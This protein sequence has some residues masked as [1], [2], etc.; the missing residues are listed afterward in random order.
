MSQAGFFSLDDGVPNANIVND[1]IDSQF[2]DKPATNRYPHSMA[3][4]II[5]SR[6]RMARILNSMD[7]LSE[8]MDSLDA[9]VTTVTVSDPVPIPTSIRSLLKLV[10]DNAK[11]DQRESYQL[12]TLADETNPIRYLPVT[13]TTHGHVM[14]IESPNRLSPTDGYIYRLDIYPEPV[15]LPHARDCMHWD[16]LTGLVVASEA[17]QHMGQVDPM[18]MNGY[19]VWTSCLSDAASETMVSNLTTHTSRYSPHRSVLD[20]VVHAPWNMYARLTAVQFDTNMSLMANAY[21]SLRFH[22]VDGAIGNRFSLMA[23]D[24]L[25]YGCSRFGNVYYDVSLHDFIV[26]LHRR[27]A[28]FTD[29]FVPLH[30]H[31]LMS[32]IG[33]RRA[34]GGGNAS[35]LDTPEGV[36][37]FRF[38]PRI[39]CH[40]EAVFNDPAVR[41]LDAAVELNHGVK[42]RYMEPVMRMVS[43]FLRNMYRDVVVA[44][45]K[46]RALDQFRAMRTL[47]DN[48]NSIEERVLKPQFDSLAGVQEL[49]YVLY[50]VVEANHTL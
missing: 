45:G 19:H 39:T 14:L 6:A 2:I 35:I 33:P 24:C 1:Y 16:H 32:H 40:Q 3:I 8:F 20:F 26:A 18:L 25:L 48:W 21:E 42:F 5:P 49:G 44:F 28:R 15:R 29:S 47:I 43:D 22:G 4:S 41:L 38:V 50:E 11:M 9:I 31:W 10:I 23:I 17:A 30:H 46:E 13:G 7:G 36:K 37:E 12:E 27:P 34:Q